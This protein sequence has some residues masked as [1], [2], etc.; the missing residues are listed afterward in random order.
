LASGR[1]AKDQLWV[2]HRSVHAPSQLHRDLAL[3]VTRRESLN[4]FFE[5]QKPIAILVSFIKND[6]NFILTYF[7][8]Q[9]HQQRF[10]KVVAVNARFT[11]LKIRQHA[12]SVRI[13]KVTHFNQVLSRLLNFAFKDSDVQETLGE[14]PCRV[15]Q[16]PFVSSWYSEI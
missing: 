15:Q 12:K 2:L 13:V 6:Q 8:L 10:K 5:A 4:H 14:V 16:W 1:F 9:V 7:H 3:C 11:I